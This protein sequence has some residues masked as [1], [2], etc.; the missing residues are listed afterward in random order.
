MYLE[1]VVPKIVGK[2]TK[3]VWYGGHFYIAAGYTGKKIT[4][5]NS[6]CTSLFRLSQSCYSRV[7]LNE[8]V[9]HTIKVYCSWQLFNQ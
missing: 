9:F 5:F 1:T 7:Y 4:I 2:K 3:N 8:Q 6:V